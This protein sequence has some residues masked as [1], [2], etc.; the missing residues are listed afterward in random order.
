MYIAQEVRE[1]AKA[2]A[3]QEPSEMRIWSEIVDLHG[4]MV[5]LLN[6]NTVNY[7]GSAPSSL[8]VFFLHNKLAIQS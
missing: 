3:D 2:V 5:L 4:E 7:T 8:G 6:Y 1:A